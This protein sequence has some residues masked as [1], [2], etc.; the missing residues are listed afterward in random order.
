MTLAVWL[1]TQSGRG[2]GWPWA[3][4]FVLGFSVLARPTNALVFPAIAWI[5][6]NRGSLKS[7]FAV[8]LGGLP[9]LAWLLFLNTILY[10]DAFT[11]GYENVGGLLELRHFWP[12]LKH[13]AVWL[14]L[15][16][17]PLAVW[18]FVLVPL[19]GPEPRSQAFTLVVWALP[20]G[21]FYAFYAFSNQDWWFTRFLLPAMPAVVIGSLMVWQEAGRRF[22]SSRANRWLPW[23]L[24]LLVILSHLVVGDWK[25]PDEIRRGHVVYEEISDWLSTHT[26][27]GDGIVCMQFSGAIAYYTDGR[28]IL[29][30]DF[31]NAAS[32]A[33]VQ[34]VAAKQEVNL[35]AALLYT[36]VNQEAV[37]S[38]RIP[39]DW[40]ER[41]SLPYATVYQ[42]NPR[43]T[44]EKPGN[45]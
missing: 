36:E 45:P 18:P 17:T 28:P 20:F 10:G 23:S 31:L 12:N 29:R 14:T 42:L 26:E 39:G 41:F 5:L 43:P 40:I 19:L 35:F 34:G 13:F 7:G 25:G 15:L 8:A 16:F 21:L 27:E 32:W 33:S 3:L 38:S 9:A 1:T 4:G 22:L 44:E 24:L 30:W 6:W 2:K 37:L 11:L